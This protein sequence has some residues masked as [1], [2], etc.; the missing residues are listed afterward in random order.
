MLRRVEPYPEVL[1]T[2]WQH[3]GAER[4]HGFVTASRMGRVLRV[5]VG[6]PYRDSGEEGLDGPGGMLSAVLNDEGSAVVETTPALP[7]ILISPD[8]SRILPAEPSQRRPVPI[9]PGDLLVLCC[10]SSAGLPHGYLR[11]LESSSSE[12]LSPDSSQ[13]LHDV[14]DGVSEG[15]AAVIT[16]SERPAAFACPPKPK[17]RHDQE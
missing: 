7:A 11:L 4:G 13:L 6:D 1:K 16:C 3:V 14:L 12:L 15:A 9:V 17:R 5:H 10:A 2:R 8:G